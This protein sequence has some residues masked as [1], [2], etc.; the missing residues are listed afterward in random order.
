VSCFAD[1]KGP[2]VEVE[3]QVTCPARCI[4]QPAQSGRQD[5]KIVNIGPL[6]AEFQIDAECEPPLIYKD[7]GPSWIETVSVEPTPGPRRRRKK[8]EPQA[9]KEIELPA[10]APIVGMGFDRGIVVKIARLHDKK[11]KT[12]KQERVAELKLKLQLRRP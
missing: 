2:F 8:V 9:W 1:G 4:L 3:S 10:G 12:S 5:V 7:V 11:T 6:A